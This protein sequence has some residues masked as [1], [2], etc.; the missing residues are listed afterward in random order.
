MVIPDRKRAESG[1]AKVPL[2]DVTLT[3]QQIAKIRN[4]TV[5]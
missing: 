5:L 4:A 3:I 2:Q 1:S